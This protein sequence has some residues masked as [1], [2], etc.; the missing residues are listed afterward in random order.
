MPLTP[1]NLDDRQFAD[2][3]AEAKTLIPRYVPEWTNFNETDPGIALT[4]LFAWMSEIIIYRLN[5]VPNLNYIKFLQL[6]GIEL[7]RGRT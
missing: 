7:F 1:P 3:V 5:Q 6:I 2:I 4:E